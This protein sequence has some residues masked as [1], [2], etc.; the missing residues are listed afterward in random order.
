VRGLVFI[1]AL[2]LSVGGCRSPQTLDGAATPKYAPTNP[3]DIRKVDSVPD[4]AIVLGD[5]DDESPTEGSIVLPAM[6]CAIR[7]AA[8]M[9]AD[10]VVV[11]EDRIDRGRQFVR[12]TAIRISK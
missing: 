2:G 9:G 1:A 12:L 11:V 7:T 8:A 6:D 10:A 3:R 4:G 5:I